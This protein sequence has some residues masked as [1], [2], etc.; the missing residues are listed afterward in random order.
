VT[1]L[2]VSLLSLRGEERR[3]SGLSNVCGG[4]NQTAG[5]K[6]LD[7]ISPELVA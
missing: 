4:L 5:L 3:Y 7:F 2:R 1:K 6:F